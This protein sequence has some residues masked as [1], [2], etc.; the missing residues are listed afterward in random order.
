ML[1][2]ILST[3]ALIATVRRLR[4]TGRLA[5]NA[6]LGYGLAATAM[7]YL[8]Y[9][10][11][12]MI[13]TQALGVFVYLSGRWA[14]LARAAA[15]FAAVGI[16]YA[17]WMGA[18]YRSFRI[19][20]FWAPPPEGFALDRIA[21]FLVDPASAYALVVGLLLFLLLN[22]LRQ[23]W[24]TEWRGLTRIPGLYLAGWL[25]IP[26][27]A[28]TIKSLVS[29]SVMVP[30]YFLI[31]A[32]AVYL[33]LARALTRL[34]PDPR[35]LA[36]LTAAFVLALGYQLVVVL[37]YYR[38]PTKTQ[39]REAAQ[40]ILHTGLAPRA[41]IVAYVWNREYFDYY[42]RQ[43]GS[44]RRVALIAGDAATLPEFRAW[45]LQTQPEQLWFVYAHRKPDGTFLN[46][47]NRHFSVVHHADFIGATAALVRHRDLRYDSRTLF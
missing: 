31:S 30:R 36:S 6:A 10:G 28:A 11:L 32:P 12:V 5:W 29:A 1:L 13:A 25:V 15:L 23:R 37:D 34:A 33:L 40:E 2:A 20:T 7:A 39:F 26:F 44:N 27:A 41:P 38:N 3:S 14:A 24:D 22:E 9:F 4:V 21:T 43:S 19:E 42:F 17:P 35:T 46:F 16:A 18:T 45:L 47:L 8:H